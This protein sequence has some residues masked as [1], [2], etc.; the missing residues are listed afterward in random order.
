MGYRRTARQKA[1]ADGA[2]HARNRPRTGRDTERQRQRQRDDGGGQ[3]AVRSPPEV[4]EA[5]SIHEV[6]RRHQGTL[7]QILHPNAPGQRTSQQTFDQCL[8]I[9]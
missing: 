7:L 1:D 4:I 2:V 5:Q 9:G 6:A 8:D 3:S